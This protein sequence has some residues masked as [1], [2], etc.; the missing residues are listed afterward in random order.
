MESL[1]IISNGGPINSP[2]ILIRAHIIL[3]LEP[4][5]T[6]RLSS[7]VN[8]GGGEILTTIALKPYFL[9]YKLWAAITSNR[10][11]P[12]LNRHTND[13]QFAYKVNKS[14]MGIIYN[15]KKIHNR[16]INTD[17]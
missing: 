12:I 11:T 14:P 13:R 15:I 8:P 7:F 2:N 10:I 17:R 6:A 3:P 5:E 1:E 9:L 4:G 16:E